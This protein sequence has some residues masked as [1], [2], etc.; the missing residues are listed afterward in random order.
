M[1]D[2]SSKS[3]VEHISGKNIRDLLVSG[4]S[5]LCKPVLMIPDYQRGYC[6]GKKQVEGLLES[7]WY[8]GW[9]Q[10]EEELLHPQFVK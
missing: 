5:E 2:R 6:W 1:N 7:I 4:S 3:I 10:Q 9:K 8:F